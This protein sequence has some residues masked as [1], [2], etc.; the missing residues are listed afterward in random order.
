MNRYFFIELYLCIFV[1]NNGFIII[2]SIKR[3]MN[4]RINNTSFKDYEFLIFTKTLI[5]RKEPFK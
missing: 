4:G 5:Y 1:S 3:L 2:K